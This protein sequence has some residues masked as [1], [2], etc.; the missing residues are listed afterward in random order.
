MSNNIVGIL[1]QRI[2]SQKKWLNLLGVIE[3]L[4]NENWKK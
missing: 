1:I 3:I 2:L 4:A